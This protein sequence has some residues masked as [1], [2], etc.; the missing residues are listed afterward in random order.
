MG[1]L[2]GAWAAREVCK[3]DSDCILSRPARRCNRRHAAGIP[4]SPD[5]AAI[6]TWRCGVVRGYGVKNSRAVVGKL[7]RGTDLKYTF[8]AEYESCRRIS[9]R[10]V[11]GGLIQ[12]G[13]ARQIDV[14]SPDIPRQIDVVSPDIPAHLP[15]CRF[16]TPARYKK[17]CADKHLRTK[18]RRIT[19]PLYLAINRIS[20][21]GA[22]STTI[23]NST[24]ASADSGKFLR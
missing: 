13:R 1:N 20:A 5:Q 9:F 22:F 11:G 16:G 7:R 12:R 10:A 18:G 14:V 2:V 6:L 19:N 8:L 4:K 24:S 17:Q 23:A 3:L 15:R 21:P